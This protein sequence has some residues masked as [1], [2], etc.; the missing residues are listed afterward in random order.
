MEDEIDTFDRLLLDDGIG[1]IPLDQIEPSRRRQM[2]NPIESKVGGYDPSAP[3][4][5]I[6]G[7]MAS[8]EASRPGHENFGLAADLVHVVCGFLATTETA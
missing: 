8:H 1:N 5:L 7:E 4:R 3:T 2:P 6:R